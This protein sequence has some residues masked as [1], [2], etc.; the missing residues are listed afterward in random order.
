LNTGASEPVAWI[1]TTSPIGPLRLT[2]NGAGLTGLYLSEYRHGPVE[3][4][5]QDQL[6]DPVLLEASR[7]LQ[8]Y[9]AGERREFDLPLAP[10]GSD[11]QRRVWNALLEIPY[12]ETI[13]YL[14]LARRL[15]DPRA[16]RAVGSANGRNPIS[17]IIPC[18]RVIGADGSLV[19]Y[20][21]GLERKRWLLRHEAAYAPLPLA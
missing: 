14:E 6:D 18:H 12:G 2:G 10:Y 5:K 16:V 9:F 1:E 19:G 15:G 21:G 4:A 3:F 13:S 7:Q 11:F 8:A 17:I 20:G